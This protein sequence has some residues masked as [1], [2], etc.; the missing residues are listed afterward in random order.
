MAA[1][2]PA[3]ATAAMAAQAIPMVSMLEQLGFATP[4]AQ[5]INNDEHLDRLAHL[6]ELVPSDLGSNLTRDLCH[7]VR[8][9]GVGSRQLVPNRAEHWLNSDA[10]IAWWWEVTD[11]PNYPYDIVI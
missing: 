5:F 8:K 1:P 7:S 4:V 9:P 3:A 11:H 6:R 10:F 2:V